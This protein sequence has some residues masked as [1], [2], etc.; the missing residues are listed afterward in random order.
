VSVEIVAQEIEILGERGPRKIAAEVLGAL[1][2]HP[3]MDSDADSGWWCV[4]H[5][6]TGR[7]VADLKHSTRERVLELARELLSLADWSLLRSTASPD[8]HSDRAHTQGITGE[9][10]AACKAA[11]A[12]AKV[13]WVA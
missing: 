2:V 12:R 5:V 11:I 9:Q 7:L 4:T 8:Q 1:A 13:A 6:P 3:E 10:I